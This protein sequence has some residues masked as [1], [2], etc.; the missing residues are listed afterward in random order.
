M[1]SKRALLNFGFFLGSFLVLESFASGWLWWNGSILGWINGISVD[2]VQVFLILVGLAMLAGTLSFMALGIKGHERKLPREGLL[3]DFAF[4]VGAFLVAAG[5]TMNVCMG[6]CN[7]IAFDASLSFL[8]VGVILVGASVY[9]WILKMKKR[10]KGIGWEGLSAATVALFL[11]NLFIVAPGGV[12]LPTNLTTLNYVIA[13]LSIIALILEI[14]FLRR[15]K[16]NPKPIESLPT[17]RV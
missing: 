1:I 13:S 15:G 6:V 14:H 9:L 5:Q 2:T 16:I 10:I 12:S 11:T 8:F 7:R 17:Q 3:V 4:I